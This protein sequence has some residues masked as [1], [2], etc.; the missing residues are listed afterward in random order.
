[1]TA[2]NTTDERRACRWVNIHTRFVF[3]DLRCV[4]TTDL[5]FVVQTTQMHTH[6]V[7]LY[8]AERDAFGKLQRVRK[9]GLNFFGSVRQPLIYWHY[10]FEC[11][12]STGVDYKGRH[13]VTLE[14]LEAPKYVIRAINA[15]TNMTT[16]PPERS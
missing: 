7:R 13:H 9:V 2:H 8:L 6:T 11:P 12:V 10:D 16:P 3:T 5:G 4:G 14:W 15:A 1:M